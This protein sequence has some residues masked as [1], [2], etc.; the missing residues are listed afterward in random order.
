VIAKN[1]NGNNIIINMP[2]L[3]ISLFFV[4]IFVP[5]FDAIVIRL[6]NPKKRR[7]MH[8]NKSDHF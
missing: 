4:M 5:V 2:F 6:K 1:V 7:E 8:Y 3:L